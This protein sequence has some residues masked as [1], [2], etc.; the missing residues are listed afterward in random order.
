M[1][2]P[3]ISLEQWRALAAVVEA[4]G[5]ARAAE[6][7]HKSQSTVSY[8]VQRIEEAL[9]VPVFEL[10]GRKAHLTPAGR[11]LYRRGRALVRQSEVVERAAAGLAAGWEPELHLAAE[12]VFPTWLL[13][14]CMETF[15]KEHP[16]IRIELFESVLGGTEELLQQG[17]VDMAIASNVPADFVGDP[18]MQVRFIAV[19]APTHPLHQLGRKLVL[20]DLS[21][22]R[23]IVVRDTGTQRTRSAAWE[24]AEQ[25]WTVSH[26]ATSIRALCMGLGFAWVAADIVREEL[27]NGTLKPLPLEEG[28]ERWGTLYL[29]QSDSAGPGTRRL[30]ELVREAADGARRRTAM[31]RPGPT[32]A[33]RNPS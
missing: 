22:H 17:R 31:L 29:V 26:K 11:V 30:A 12:I 5:Y 9:G 6:R 19:A 28:A 32:A 1:S 20:D 33:D 16:D 24:V 3:R 7:L 27:A 25:R 23:H 8:A 14:E 13:L 18:L 21:G 15:A 10:R 4:G 2:N